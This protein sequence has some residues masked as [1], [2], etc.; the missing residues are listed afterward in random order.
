VAHATRKF[1][2]NRCRYVPADSLATPPPAETKESVRRFYVE[3]TFRN[4]TSAAISVDAGC[5]FYDAKGA[6]VRF[7]GS[8]LI[9]TANF[10]YVK[11]GQTEHFLTCQFDPQTFMS[12][13]CAIP[14]GWQSV[15][16]TVLRIY[17]STNG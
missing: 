14:T 8:P 13:G 15:S 1:G 16:H 9:S 6:E 7:Q 5:R 4:G 2:V 17:G 10:V 11:P 12:Q 3:A